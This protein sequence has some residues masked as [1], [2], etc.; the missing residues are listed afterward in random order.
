MNFPQI[1]MPDSLDPAVYPPVCFLDMDGTCFHKGTDDWLP[2]A[3]ERIQAIASAGHRIVAFTC[4]PPGP[5]YHKFMEIGVPLFGHIQ[6]P[7]SVW[8]YVVDDVLVP[9]LCQGSLE[10]LEQATKEVVA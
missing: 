1:T 5:W 2:G 4:R 10:N 9:W 7:L 8:Y 3:V 6:K